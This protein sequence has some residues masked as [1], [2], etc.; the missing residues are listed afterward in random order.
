MKLWLDQRSPGVGPG[1]DDTLALAEFLV[2]R[3]SPMCALREVLKLFDKHGLAAKGHSPSYE[4]EVA[5]GLHKT[6][7]NSTFLA[8]YA[9]R[10]LSLEDIKA[11][12]TFLGDA[13]FRDAH[14]R[15]QLSVNPKYDPSSLQFL[16]GSKGWEFQIQHARCIDQTI[17][18]EHGG[19]IHLRQGAAD[20][21]IAVHELVHMLSVPG[22]AAS[23]GPIFNEGLTE[24]IARSVCSEAGIPLSDDYYNLE[25]Q[26][27]EN[28]SPSTT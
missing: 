27:V 2:L 7:S 26:V 11:A 9:K 21:H 4:D 24:T 28:Y 10:K 22:L 20:L 1:P 13:G 17:A 23:L 19:R 5:T 14:L 25:R 6:L 3:P 12:L 15:S 16:G 18:F 8:K